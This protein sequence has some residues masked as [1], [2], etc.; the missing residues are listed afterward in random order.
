MIS[1]YDPDSEFLTAEQCHILELQNSADDEGC[2]IA[3]ARVEPGVTTQLHA[4]RGT[5]ER[6]VILS[7]EG[8]VELAGDEPVT[9]RQLD[10]VTIPAGESQRISNVG[11]EDLIFLC[12]CTPRFRQDNYQ[13]LEA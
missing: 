2:S 13:N 4:L 11:S 7:G 6:Y 12:I 1:R 5:I 9:V 8:Q 3:R 10:V